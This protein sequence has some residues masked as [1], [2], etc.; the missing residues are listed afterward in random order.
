MATW[1]PKKRTAMHSMHLE[2]GAILVDHGGWDLPFEYTSAEEEVKSAMAR[3]GFCDVSPQGK[4]SLQG[5]DLPVFLQGALPGAAAPPVHGVAVSTLKASDNAT[6]TEVTLSRFAE[7]EAFLTCSSEALDAVSAA[8]RPSGECLHV[9][10]VTANF[11]GISIIGPSGGLLLAKL[12]DL[13]LRPRE[14]PDLSCAQGMAV[15]VYAIVVRKDIGDMPA[16]HLYVTRDFGAYVWEAIAEAAH[17]LSIGPIG[18]EAFKR[19]SGEI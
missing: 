3:A 8:L 14:F 2:H 15:E 4:L 12:T 17:E 18:T 13:D 11:A 5:R 16:Y 1:T 19:L 7:D 6:P 10:D 9:V